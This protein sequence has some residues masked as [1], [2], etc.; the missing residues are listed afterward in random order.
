MTTTTILTSAPDPV[1]AE[2]VEK[3]TARLQAGEAVDLDEVL[4][5]HPAQADQLRPML[6]MLQ[7][8]ADLGRSAVQDAGALTPP[9]EEPGRVLGDFRIRREIG[10]GGMGVV[11]E[12]QQVS[13]GRPVA[14][15]VLPFA[16]TLDPRQLQRFQNEAQAAAQLHHTNIVPVYAVGCERGVHYYAM[17]LIGGRTLAALIEEMRARARPEGV[18]AASETVP[19]AGGALTVQRSHHDREFFRT[20]ARLGVQAAEALEH[21]HGLGVVHRD[22]KPSNL[23]LDRRGNLWVTDFGLA[24]FPQNGGL[25]L[26]GDL[27][28]T[29]RYMSPEQASARPGAVD[30]ATDIYSLGVTLYELLTLEP[31][32]GGTDRNEILWH[33]AMAEPRP[34]RRLDRA[35]PAELET[36]VLKA[37][38]REP[39]GRYAT[40]QELADD[41]RRFL[42]DKPIRARRPSLVERVRKWSR[43]HRTVVVAGV[44]ALAFAAVALAV[45]TLLIWQAYEGEKMA[46]AAEKRQRRLAEERR[47]QAEA[48]WQ[49]AHRAANDLYTEAADKL[50]DWVPHK[51]EVRRTILLRALKFYQEF[52]REQGTEPALRYEK[53]RAYWRVGNIQ[54]Q[55][56]QHAAAEKAYRRALPLLT[57]L[58]AEYPAEPKYRNGVGETYH[59]LAAQLQDS[60]RLPQAEAAYRQTLPWFSRLVADY[61][62][63]T[64]YRYNLATCYYNL[65]TVLYHRDRAAAAEK[66]YRQALALWE[67][68]VAG[69]PK[70]PRHRA[71]LVGSLTGLA[72][73]LLTTDRLPQAEKV[74]RRA[75]AVCEALVKQLPHQPEYRFHLATVKNNLGNLLSR[76]RQFREAAPL[77]TQAL[78]LHSRLVAEYPAKPQ[79][80]HGLA[81]ATLNTAMMLT[82]AGK[83]DLA[84]KGFRAA[85]TVLT[86]LTKNHPRV[87]SYQQDLADCATRLGLLLRDAGKFQDAESFLRQALAAR[88]QLAALFPAAARHESNVGG[89][90]NNLAMILLARGE[91]AEARRCLETAIR[92]QQAAIR[93]DAGQRQFREFLA[94]HHWNLGRVWL[95]L[96]DHAAA[97][98]AAAELPRILP[99]DPERYVLAALLL[100]R[101]LPLAEKDSHLPEPKRRQV[102][103]GYGD[104]VVALLR[105]AAARGY[106]DAA[107]LKKDPVLQRLASR[108]DFRQLLLELEKTRKAP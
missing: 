68:L 55:L 63:G 67:K 69:S 7:V 103:Q 16:S 102:I 5:Q 28:G 3:L 98:Q 57:G 60:G 51:E 75:L 96:Q 40:A 9:A 11:Y 43:R 97:A 58:A 2:L 105:R 29:L 66:A 46:S 90:L 107:A 24:R 76:T 95:G 54:L 49:Y 88:E 35:I 80:R 84:N 17:Q 62:R 108:A 86:W 85:L 65:G 44:L 36:I 52:V 78:Q 15:K 104:E 53:G 12:A 37:M 8:L 50:L 34:P 74:Y 39:A 32:V 25:T 79:L 19:D 91:L 6:P 61:P 64:L 92:R 56:G 30:H 41:L 77:C 59:S 26:T 33:I 87:A 48:R 18:A 83:S 101:C 100:A 21:A 106:R 99:D 4:R 82:D 45:S 89:A 94:N 20:I 22:V 93:A 73:V 42:E 47:R 31:A 38:A 23:L 27:V 10:R 72:T 14:L 13:L 81:K 70:R 71:G 1:L